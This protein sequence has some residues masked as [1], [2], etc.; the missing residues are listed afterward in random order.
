MISVVCVYHNLID[1]WLLNVKQ[2]MFH[3]YSGPKHIKKK[4]NVQKWGRNGRVRASTFYCHWK[5]VETWVE[6][7]NCAFCDGYDAPTLEWKL[8]K[9]FL[10]W[11]GILQTYHPLTMIQC[12]A[13]CMIT[14]QLPSRGHPSPIH[15]RGTCWAVL[16]FERWEPSP[17]LRQT[18]CMCSLVT[19]VFFYS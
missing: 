13:F 6:M 15:S 2:Q 19:G 4:T 8:Q 7:K 18:D 16:W 1:F 9:W 17:V 5:S 3:V 10:M 14:W 11:C 12:Q